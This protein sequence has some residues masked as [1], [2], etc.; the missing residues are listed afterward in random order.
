MAGVFI[1]FLSLTQFIIAPVF[2]KRNELRGKLGSKQKPLVEM[3]K[4]AG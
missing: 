2:E 4:L 3:N 1:A